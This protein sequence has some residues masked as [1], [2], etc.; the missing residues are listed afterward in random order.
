V[1]VLRGLTERLRETENHLKGVIVVLTTVRGQMIVLMHHVHLAKGMIV[2]LTTGRDRVIVRIRRVH[3]VKGVSV[4][5]TTGRDRVIVHIRRVH[6]VKGVIVVHITGRD[7]VIVHIRRVHL[8]KGMSVVHITGRDQVIV[9]IRL[10]KKELPLVRHLEGQVAI[11]HPAQHVM[12]L[13][14]ILRYA[15]NASSHHVKMIVDVLQS[16]QSAIHLRVVIGMIR[17]RHLVHNI[18]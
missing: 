5:L 13:L 8:V 18:N 2:V 9:R 4:V 11:L 16:F 10:D 6:L 7:R 3:L 14:E 15:M 12:K 1:I 17:P